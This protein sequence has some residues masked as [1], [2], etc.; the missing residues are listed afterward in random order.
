MLYLNYCIS[1][2]LFL[3]L[4][5]IT[6][7]IKDKT[8]IYFIIIIL[9][10]LILNE[11]LKKKKEYFNVDETAEML[12]DSAI[13]SNKMDKVSTK[14]TNLEENIKDLTD[15][16]KQ[17]RIKELYK[18]N[19][20]SKDF[21]MTKAQD[22]QDNELDFME[23]EIDILTKLYKTEVEAIDRKDIKAIP[24]LSSCKVRNEGSLYKNDSNKSDADTLIKKLENMDT[25]KNN[26]ITSETANSLYNLVSNEKI[27]DNMDINLNLL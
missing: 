26:G 20:E 8:I 27:N 13:Q 15:V 14:I 9:I 5:L 21:D 10:V 22:K 1:A 2:I 23:R 19:S 25:L 7:Y 11:F 6:F 12:R 24:V 16:V 17:Q 3:V 4:I 18:Q